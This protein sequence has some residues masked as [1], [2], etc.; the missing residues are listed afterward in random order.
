MK[1]HFIGI[2][3]RAM[4]GIA[5]ALAQAGHRVSGS[6]EGV[7]EPMR[8][9]LANAGIR[10]TTFA[11]EHVPPDADVVVAGRRVTASNPELKSARDMGLACLSFPAFLH[12]HCLSHSRNGVVAGGVG[13]TTTTA[14]L[15][16]MLERAGR[17]PDYL[18]GGVARN[19][20][21]SCRLAGSRLAVLEGDEYASG[22]DDESPKFMHYRPEVVVV[23]NLV[24][25]HPDLYPTPDRLYQAFAAFVRL[26]PAGGCLICQ[27]DDPTSR[28]LAEE[29]GCAVVTVGTTGRSDVCIGDLQLRERGTSFTLDGVRFHMPLHGPMNVR[30]AAM[31]AL[32]AARLGVSLA[33]ASRALACF[34]GLEDHQEVFEAGGR[35]VVRDKASHPESLRELCVA[36]RQRFPGRR[37]VSVMQP[38]ATG[39][40]R[41]IYQRELPA[42]LAAFDKVILTTPYEH[43]PPSNAAWE[44]DPFCLDTLSRDL[45]A[46][47]VKVEHASAMPALPRLVVDLSEPGDVVLLSLRE[48]F[49]REAAAVIRAL[50]EA[51][52]V[53]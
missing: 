21:Q 11:P 15:A 2:A 41:W 51:V 19:F 30:N 43:K 14:L 28:R 39:G 4:G 22:P 31:A 23:T 10:P 44:R 5:V 45:E 38:R 18:I 48:Q 32:A 7:Y 53:A 27:A 8:S 47:R 25:D 16:W 20:E 40:R 9:R 42:S 3:G 6:D 50:S 34:E 17:R 13:K 46:L 29:A 37:L 36:L 49:S 1:V 52:T 33:D 26:I 24:S 35:I 12:A